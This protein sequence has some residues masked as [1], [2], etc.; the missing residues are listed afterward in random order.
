MVIDTRFRPG[1]FYKPPLPENGAAY[2]RYLSRLL[3]SPPR[4]L[5][6]LSGNGKASRQRRLY[7]VLG[8]FFFLS[9]NFQRLKPSSF[10][11][12]PQVAEYAPHRLYR[13]GGFPQINRLLC[14]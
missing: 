4:L 11:K 13:L 3:N 7:G 6:T 12:L 8:L 1:C 14:I 5:P 10:F 2:L 9:S